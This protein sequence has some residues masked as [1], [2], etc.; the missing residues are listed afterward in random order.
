[1]KKII[2]I[3]L[4]A[5]AISNVQAQ[6]NRGDNLFNINWEIGFPINNKFT[7]EATLSGANFNFRHFLTDNISVGVGASF[8]LFD[9]YYGRATYNSSDGNSAVTTDMDREIYNIPITANAHYYLKLNNLDVLHPFIGVGIGAQYSSQTI[10]YNA[11]EESGHSWGFAVRPEI[12]A[13]VNF[14]EMFGLNFAFGYDFS[15]S[16][17]V[18]NYPDL[19]YSTLQNWYLQLGLFWNLK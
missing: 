11:F 8:I 14:N 5:F 10:Y 7:N 15:T 6:V 18:F 16:D 12:G 19:N 4:A 1:M 3:L 9:Q 17:S 13:L 2:A